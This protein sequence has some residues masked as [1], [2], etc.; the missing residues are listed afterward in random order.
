MIIIK[1]TACN[2]L[3]KKLSTKNIFSLS[4]TMLFQRFFAS[5][6]ANFLIIRYDYYCQIN[7]V[8]RV[9]QKVI[10]KKYFYSIVNNAVSAIFRIFA[11]KKLSILMFFNIQTMT[12]TLL[13]ILSFRL[14]NGAE[15]FRLFIFFD[16][17]AWFNQSMT[18]SLLTCMVSSTM[19]YSS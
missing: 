16:C 5:C 2:A 4:L 9:A 14:Y 3:H 8:Q 18:Q 12:K 15:V 19:K 11:V 6:V 13:N 17:H 1:L 10:N 7:C